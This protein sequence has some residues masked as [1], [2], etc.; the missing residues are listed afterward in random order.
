[1]IERLAE[2]RK[3]LRQVLAD[4]S[5]DHDSVHDLSHADRVWRNAQAIAEGEGCQNL[6]VLVAGAYLHDIVSLPKDHPDRALS[7]TLSAKAAAKV[8]PDLGFTPSEV[9]ACKHVI[10]A[11]SFSAN[12]KAET[13]EAMILQDADRLDALGA[14]GIARL[15]AVSGGLDRPLMN[16]DDP[17]AAHR[18]LDDQTYALD[19]FATKLMRL[20]AMMQTATGRKLA[21]D[22]ANTMGTFL[23]NLG[24][25]VCAQ[26][27]VEF[28]P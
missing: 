24:A 18:A 26:P 2:L 23:Q 6:R 4:N 17:F 7:S 16:A 8:L 21:A 3:K 15:F 28:K 9:N 22:R 25:E 12:I 27:T 5:N 14:I 1:M 19:H 10:E 11:H 13:P 20:P